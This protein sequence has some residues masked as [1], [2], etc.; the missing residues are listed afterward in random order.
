MYFIY[1]SNRFENNYRNEIKQFGLKFYSLNN[2][3]REKIKKEYDRI[4]SKRND[5]Y[6][7]LN[8]NEEGL[9]LFNYKKRKELEVDRELSF[10]IDMIRQEKKKPTFHK[11]IDDFLNNIL[12]LEIDSK[13]LSKYIDSHD[14]RIF[15]HQFIDFHFIFDSNICNKKNDKEISLPYQ[16]KRMY[17]EKSTPDFMDLSKE[18]II[19]YIFNFYEQSSYGCFA[20]NKSF[21]N[22]LSCISKFS[23]SISSEELF[24]FIEILEIFFTNSRLSQNNILNDTL[25]IE[26]LL[27]KKDSNS[28]EK[29]FVLKTGIIY[30]NSKLKKYYSNEDLSVIL[31]YLYGMRS[32]IIHGSMEKI[33]ECYNKFSLKVKAIPCSK[34]DSVSKMQ[35]KIMIL[36]FTER[37]SYEFVKLVLIYW[38]NNY[39]EI[40]FLRNN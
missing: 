25:I 28:I 1:C 8:K 20:V 21:E 5:I 30:K 34:F 37:L 39:D 22:Y 23:N 6:K 15:I 16:M 19:K 11:N 33:F 35:K 10:I 40:S 32:T 4:Y 7:S 27:I 3:Q 14:F 9:V 24:K 18:L 17:R 2:I 26:S 36:K 29:E 12:V 38:I 31:H 13:R